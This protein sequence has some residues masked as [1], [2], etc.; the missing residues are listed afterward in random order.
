MEGNHSPNTFACEELRL[1]TNLATR[2]CQP[3]ILLTEE[4]IAF[5][6]ENSCEDDLFFFFFYAS[7]WPFDTFIHPLSARSSGSFI[8]DLP[9]KKRTAPNG[10]A[11]PFGDA[12]TPAPSVEGIPPLDIDQGLPNSGVHRTTPVGSIRSI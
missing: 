3:N 4:D 11:E 7:L 8:S 12:L 6:I 1:G 5:S 2:S 10:S 9:V